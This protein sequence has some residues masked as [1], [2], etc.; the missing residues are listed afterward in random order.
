MIRRRAAMPK[1]S[2][3]LQ[4]LIKRTPL[5]SRADSDRLLKGDLEH[6]AQKYAHQALVDG[7]ESWKV[8]FALEGELGRGFEASVDLLPITS[9][10]SL[11]RWAFD[12]GRDDVAIRA[13]RRLLESGAVAST[14]RDL[15]DRFVGTIRDVQG[16]GA[17]V[18]A[19]A[20]V[21]R[22]L[23]PLVAV[24]RRSEAPCFRVVPS[25]DRSPHSFGG[26]DIAM[27]ACEGCGEKVRLY[28][29]F[30]VEAEPSLF[31]LV[32]TWAMFPLLGC[33][34]C[35]AWSFRTDYKLDAETTVARIVRVYADAEALRVAGHVRTPTPIL[36]RAS[37]SL[38]LLTGESSSPEPLVGGDPHWRGNPQS[39][40]CWECNRP[41]KLV[42]SLA[43][44]RGFKPELTIE[45]FHDHFACDTCK[46]LSVIAQ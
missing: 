4:T 35:R 17:A 19:K 39:V 20:L 6:G 42:A 27:P 31:S 40:T 9:C 32:P 3:A 16:E 36:P 30:D 11:A 26:H 1:L 15:A 45:G 43:T 22:A 28:F 5:A 7:G 33:G 18:E 10:E 13:Y 21:D 14:A 25:S 24:R 38:V 8:Y 41:M 34:S 29:S 12:N 2:P 46:T 44:P 37:A 23:P